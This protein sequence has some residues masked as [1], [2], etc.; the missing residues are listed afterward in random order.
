MTTEPVHSQSTAVLP[1]V[2]AAFLI[3]LVAVAVFA[4]LVKSRPSAGRSS[5]AASLPGVEVMEVRSEALP[6]RIRATGVVTPARQI[7]L[8][9]EVSGRIVEQSSQLLPGGRFRK[10]ELM[11]R[12]DG[13]DYEA[14]VEAEEA[15]LRQAELE[16]E[17]EQGRG[18]VAQKE[19][20]LLGD[21][22]AP[23]EAR[24]ALRE[25]HRA[26]AE[27]NLAA[28][29]ASLARAQHNLA[30]TELRAP[31]NA[32]VI[33]EGIDVGQV[34]APGTR[35]ATLAGTDRFWILASV[36]VERMT[37][38]LIP[39]FNAEE[40]SAVQVV[41]KLGPDTEIER[42]GQVLRLGGQLDPQTR[43]AQLIVAV[44]GPMDPEG[45][46]EPRTTELPLLPGAFVDL[47]IE[48]LDR[49]DTLSVPR[50]AV[51]EGNRVWL[52]DSDDKL[53]VREVTV[54]WS[55]SDVAYVVDGLAAGDRV[56]TSPLSLPLQ[57]QKVQ[58][59]SAPAEAKDVR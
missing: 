12:I 13:R 46:T 48:G 51:Y 34:V 50:A 3:V 57:G 14:A 35:V 39:G 15:R 58:I 9:P 27:Q 31:F 29:R 33:D 8:S 2:A 7:T 5:G 42:R 24:L 59:V 32:M 1:R 4:L 19:W 23:E 43:K 37:G 55:D 6:V 10:G 26:L 17:L 20:A 47:V 18:T 36:P 54:G 11:A 53:A 21:Q 44:D 56:V 52:A 16:W 40:G 38:I 30:R 22:R 28:A 41:Q 25:P 49:P 45:A